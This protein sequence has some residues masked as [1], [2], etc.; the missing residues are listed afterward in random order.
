MRKVRVRTAILLVVVLIGAVVAG[1][2]FLQPERL[3]LKQATRVPLKGGMP[4]R[5]WWLP[6]HRILLTRDAPRRRTHPGE[7]VH[8]RDIIVTIYVYDLTTRAEKPLRRLSRLF[9]K[10]EWFG[11][12]TVSPDGKWWMWSPDE[13]S[14]SVSMLDGSH[15]FRWV[16]HNG[17]DPVLWL[18]DSSGVVSV[19]L[20]PAGDSADICSVHPPHTPRSFPFHPEKMEG[21]E[22]TNI[23]DYFLVSKDRMLVMRSGYPQNAIRR[24]LERSPGGFTEVLSRI[25]RLYLHGLP[26]P[27]AA[28]EMDREL[29]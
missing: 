24:F 10:S 11:E 5:Y 16:V 7:V 28:G 26:D 17:W 13:G 25:D 3:L 20:D 6:G 18:P 22:L 9:N 8:H 29:A 19:Y 4:R 23:D 12:R 15:H 1:I 2:R 27:C 14:F 21:L